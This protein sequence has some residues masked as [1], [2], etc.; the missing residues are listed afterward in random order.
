MH[1]KEHCPRDDLPCGPDED[2]VADAQKHVP[3]DLLWDDLRQDVRMLMIT[4][5]TY[6]E[7]LKLL[8]GGGPIHHLLSGYMVQL[9]LAQMIDWGTLDL[10]PWSK[11]V[12][13]SNYLDAERIWTGIRVVDGRGLEKWPSLDKCDRKLQKLRDVAAEVE[14]INGALS[15]SSDDETQDPYF[16]LKPGAEADNAQETRDETK[17]LDDGADEVPTNVTDT[18]LK[19]ASHASSG[20]RH[21]SPS[22]G[23]KSKA[24][25]KAPDTKVIKR[26]KTN[27]GRAKGVRHPTDL[28][29]RD[30]QSLS[31]DE[32]LIIEDCDR[33]VTST[34]RVFG[35]KMKFFDKVQTLGFPDYEPHKHE[36]KYLKNRW[37]ME[38]WD[39]FLGV[40]RVKKS[41]TKERNVVGLHRSATPLKEVHTARSQI[42]ARG[43]HESSTLCSPGF[44]YRSKEFYFHRVR[45]LSK[46][47]MR[48]L[49]EYLKSMEEHVEGWWYILHWFTMSMEDG[50]AKELHLWRH[51]CRETL[52]RNFLLLVQRLEKIDKFPKTL[53]YEPGLWILPNTICY[54]IFKDPSV[55]FQTV[56]GVADLRAELLEL[57]EREPART[58]WA[59]AA[60]ETARLEHVPEAF[61]SKRLLPKI[62]R[63]KNLLPVPKPSSTPK[64]RTTK[65]LY[66]LRLARDVA[67]AGSN[68]D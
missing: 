37:S 31:E 5:L 47:V 7:A 25:S 36:T 12:P 50:R 19:T 51:Q 16:S 43:S 52:V 63:A 29:T 59:D 22:S 57:D 38:A 64:P 1:P 13:E 41:G 39:E 26:V 54:W 23:K 42:P 35:I 33:D 56:S 66:E 60:S 28:T 53:G 3:D 10:T 4:G 44:K 49:R 18:S 34:F 20:T 55:N 68:S 62:E 8:H 27:T 40:V 21:P 32:L 45:D 24:T 6:E 67:T 48:G 15:E 46:G 14:M 9:M 61:V 11:Y 30:F 2:L 65:E 17:D 58:L